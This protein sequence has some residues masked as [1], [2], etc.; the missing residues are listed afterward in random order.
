MNRGGGMAGGGNSNLTYTLNG[1]ETR[2]TQDSPMGAIPVTLKA[3]LQGDILKLTQTRT[4]NT[5]MGE[6]TMITKE[7][8]SL[9][10]D[11]KTLTVKRETQTPRGTNSSEL[12]F[13][14][15]TYLRTTA[16]DRDSN[17]PSERVAVQTNTGKT[18]PTLKTV[19]GGVVNGK[20][21][22][23]AVPKYP[24]GA[25]AARASGQVAVAVTIDEEGK[26][27]SAS[28]VSGHPLLRAAAEE[29]ARASIFNPTTFEGRPV[30]VTGTIIY[31]FVP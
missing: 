10:A 19:S 11:G 23:L 2:T 3:N 1:K 21:R 14:K 16:V 26:V 4:I 6:I 18:S 7:I 12:V 22:N 13:A 20:A 31:N 15:A 8:W 28:A 5:Q 29:A 24:D 9:S 17:N 27:I 25:R 30:K